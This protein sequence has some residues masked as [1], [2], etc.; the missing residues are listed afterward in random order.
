MRLPARQCGGVVMLGRSETLSSDRLAAIRDLLD[1][2]FDGAFSNVDWE[3]ACGG[4]H[5]WVED[6][7]DVVA[8]GALVRR[9]LFVGSIELTAGYI[10]AVAAKP[11]RQGAGLGSA[12]MNVLGNAIRSDYALGA[13]STGRSEFYERLGWQ[14]WQG[15]TF[16][17]QSNGDL[18]RTHEEDGGV[19]VLCTPRTPL[20]DLTSSIACALRKGD[21][22]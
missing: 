16:V 3:H 2:A 11:A 9:K 8:H 10:E 1:E 19:L 5:A 6:D 13:L 18:Y 21:A 20:I 15:P 17:R 22:W 7:G 4:T 12:V 14:R